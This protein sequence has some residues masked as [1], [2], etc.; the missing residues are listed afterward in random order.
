M[1]AI[2]QLDFAMTCRQIIESWEMP[3]GTRGSE[4]FASPGEEQIAG[5]TK[6]IMY[7]TQTA[8]S[9]ISIKDLD[10]YIAE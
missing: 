3:P 2:A 7:L 5:D 9:P 8:V 4:R 1:N 10:R 6:V